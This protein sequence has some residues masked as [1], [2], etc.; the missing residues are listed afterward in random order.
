MLAAAVV[1][2]PGTIAIAVPVTTVG[3]GYNQF[4]V[5]MAVLAALV[6]IAYCMFTARIE[7]RSNQLVFVDLFTERA[8]ERDSI[9]AVTDNNGVR[10]RMATGIECTSVAYGSSLIQNVFPSARYARVGNRITT[11]MASERAASASKP[12]SAS[13]HGQHVR[14]ASPQRV[15]RRAIPLIGTT[16]LLVGQLAAWVLYQNAAVLRPLFGY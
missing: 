10:I 14:G 15:L 2:V 1:V 4:A 5:G 3:A 9:S 12:D 8:I 16:S 13:V 7:V 6:V 11:W